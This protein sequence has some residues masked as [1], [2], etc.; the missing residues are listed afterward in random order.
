MDGAAEAMGYDCYCY[1]AARN[2]EASSLPDEQVYWQWHL[3]KVPMLTLPS[4]SGLLSSS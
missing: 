2:E 3:V 1:Y 4:R